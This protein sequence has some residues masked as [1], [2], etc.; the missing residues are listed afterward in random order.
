MKKVLFFFLGFLTS[1]IIVGV[2][3]YFYDNGIYASLYNSVFA[4]SQPKG[5]KEQRIYPTVFVA[6][7][8]GKVEDLAALINSITSNKSLPA[9]PGL[10]I[11]FQSSK[12]FAYKVSGSVNNSDPIINV[13]MVPS[14][15]SNS[16]TVNEQYILEV[17]QYL[18][19]NYSVAQVNLVG[20]S[21]SANGGLRY[22]MDYSKSKDL[23]AVV[24]YVSLVGQYNEKEPM[25]KGETIVSVLKNGPQ[26]K[27][28][29]YNWFA[30]HCQGLSSQ[31]SILLI[32]SVYNPKKQDDG[33]LSI[34]NTLSVNS[35]LVKNGNKV[36]TEIITG[37]NTL[38]NLTA[39]NSQAQSLVEK[40]LYN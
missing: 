8:G 13:V 40:F 29:T 10:T 20:Y 16:N 21:S 18:K 15:A 38:H 4:Q 14:A 6:G 22:L 9:K 19:K 17:M 12:T 11:T 23:P 25:A 2:G 37:A 32:A 28:S 36:Q 27:S 34:G 1:L 5:N 39:S 3:L 35:L 33:V 7:S 26:L 30:D 31:M 24:K